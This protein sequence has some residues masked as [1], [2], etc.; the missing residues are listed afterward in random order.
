MNLSV[1]VV[2]NNG[3]VDALKAM[4]ELGNYASYSVISSSC[5]TDLLLEFDSIKV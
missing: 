3:E 5:F 1:E 2:D 4:I